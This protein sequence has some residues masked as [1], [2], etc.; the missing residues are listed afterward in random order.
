MRSSPGVVLR[1]L[2]SGTGYVDVSIALSRVLHLIEMKVLRRRLEGVEQLAA[3]M[4]Q[5]GRDEEWLVVIDA[6]PPRRK[7]GVG[8]RGGHQPHRPAATGPSVVR[9]PKATRQRSRRRCR[10]HPQRRNR[11]RARSA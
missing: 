1:E 5:E 10:Q 8:P 7:V 11:Q 9:S 6:R 4:Q 2:E 3:Y